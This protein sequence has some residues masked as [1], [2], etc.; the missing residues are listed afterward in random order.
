MDLWMFAAAG[1]ELAV[2]LEQQ[3]SLGQHRDETL[4]IDEAR[5]TRE[6]GAR[7]FDL[8]PSTWH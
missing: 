8:R 4:G 3:Q 7:N 6:E 1:I 5:G 2:P